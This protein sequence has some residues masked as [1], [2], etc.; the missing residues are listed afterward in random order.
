MLTFRKSICQYFKSDNLCVQLIIRHNGVNSFI[1]E[2]Y[3]QIFRSHEFSK[4]ESCDFFCEYLFKKNVKN[5]SQ[6]SSAEILILHYVWQK[7]PEKCTMGSNILGS[8]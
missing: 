4:E 3:C 7:I 1:K 2:N 6:N 8:H 5:Y